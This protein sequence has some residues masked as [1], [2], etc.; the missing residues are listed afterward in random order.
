M[1]IPF[2]AAAAY[3]I[4]IVFLVLYFRFGF[5]TSVELF[6][7]AR[8]RFFLNLRIYPLITT[9]YLMRSRSAGTIAING[10]IKSL[11]LCCAIISLCD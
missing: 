1:I 9:N 4:I 5:A 6:F 8:I 3:S 7:S 10:V 11:I 2:A